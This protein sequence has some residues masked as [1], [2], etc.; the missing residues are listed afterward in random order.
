MEA[1]ARAAAV[2][3]TTACLAPRAEVSR[4][5]SRACVS[6]AS[7]RGN[8]LAAKVPTHQ[9]T[10]SRRGVVC[11]AKESAASGYAAA[12]L[13]V[14]KQTS[15][16]EAIHTDLEALAPLTSSPEV[17]VF[18][19]NPVIVED[20]KKALLKT[21]AGEAKLNAYTLNFLNLLVDKKRINILNEIIAI[22]EE[23][24]CEATDTQVAI[25]TSAVKLENSQQALIA[26]K[27]QS[28][29]GAKNI[30]LKNVI[31]SSL[32]AGFVVK[33]GRD[34][35]ELIDMS[36]KGQLDRLAEQLDLSETALLTA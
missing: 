24:Y 31:D 9:A 20:K 14:G 34:G 11:M 15:S 1:V 21:L 8:A 4:S 27:L 17:A 13:D 3:P 5:S 23:L 33:Y 6:F 26:K 36:V 2:A 12:L 25:V 7:S 22:F 18:L 10:G 32:I 29:T 35:S 19:A 28:M 30:K 16:L